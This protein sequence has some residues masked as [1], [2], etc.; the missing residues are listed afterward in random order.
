MKNFIKEAAENLEQRLIATVL[1]NEEYSTNEVDYDK[2]YSEVVALVDDLTF[3]HLDIDITDRDKIEYLDDNQEVYDFVEGILLSVEDIEDVDD[4]LCETLFEDSF[5]D[6]TLVQD[7]VT[8]EVNM[9][10]LIE[11]LVDIQIN[12]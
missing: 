10:K 8:I 2:A 11:Y 7:T 4:Y 6:E 5:L 12:N 9:P 3:G 1:P